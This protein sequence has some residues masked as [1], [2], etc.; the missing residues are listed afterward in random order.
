MLRPEQGQLTT[1]DTE[2]NK[3][4]KPRRA[5]RTLR[6]ARANGGGT[7]PVSGGMFPKGAEC[8]RRGRNDSE[9]GGMFPKGAECFRRVEECFREERDD[10]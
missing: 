8:F 3:S 10:S 5:L 2:K 1:E 7:I 6:R 9:G 4:D